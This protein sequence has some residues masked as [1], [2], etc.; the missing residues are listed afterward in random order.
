MRKR[1]VGRGSR[2]AGLLGIIWV[3]IE[4][5]GKGKGREKVRRNGELPDARDPTYN[6]KG[7]AIEKFQWH[8]ITRFLGASPSRAARRARLHRQTSWINIPVGPKRHPT[9][10]QLGSPLGWPQRCPQ[11]AILATKRTK[12]FV[13]PAYPSL[14]DI[15]YCDLRVSHPQ[16]AHHKPF[17]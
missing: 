9:G 11:T 5:G 3:L 15:L 17:Y 16:D 12:T 1:K 8:L 13:T 4:S 14:W 10:G 6:R 2:K 7:Q